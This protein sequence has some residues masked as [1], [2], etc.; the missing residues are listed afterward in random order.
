V[1][2]VLVPLF[3][4]QVRIVYV[5]SKMDNN[6]HLKSYETKRFRVTKF[7]NMTR[8]LIHQM[9]DEMVTMI[10]LKKD[11]RMVTTFK[12]AQTN[13]EGSSIIRAPKK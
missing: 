5:I 4:S 3:T 11:N 8:R 7:L 2:F 13:V 12:G 1:F 6:L 10:V 9:W